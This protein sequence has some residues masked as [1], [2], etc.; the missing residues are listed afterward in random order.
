MMIETSFMKFGKDLIGIIGKTNPRT[1]QQW[2]K[3][4]AKIQRSF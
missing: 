4:S 2:G 1:I 3:N